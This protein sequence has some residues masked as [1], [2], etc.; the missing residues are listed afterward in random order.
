MAFIRKFYTS[1]SHFGHQGML[2]F[3]GRPFASVAEMDRFLIE[4][5]NS[6][7]GDADIVYHVGD[8]AVG[9]RDPVRIKRIFD[10]LRGRKFL[11]LGNHDIRSDG[12]I[13][14]S[15]AAL[16]WEAPPVHMMETL[17]E[18]E[19]V[20]LCHYS[21]RVWSASHHGSWHFFGH[22]HGSLPPHGRSRDVGV[23]CQDCAFTPRTFRELT[24]NMSGEIAA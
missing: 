2:E 21:L 1:D 15:I 9:D 20:I 4:A 10:Q 22:S 14:P 17:D 13:H 7:V 12:S 18:G 24:A 6:T 23:D 8:F 19:R 16:G 5:W 3:A 11:V